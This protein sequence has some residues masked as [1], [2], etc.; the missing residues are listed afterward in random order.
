MS[1]E[2]PNRELPDGNGFTLA[3]VAARFN[4]EMVDALVE[5]VQNSLL[6]AGAVVEVI[7]VP[8]AWELP[9]GAQ[10]AARAGRFDAVIALGVVIAGDTRHHEHIADATGWGIQEVSLKEH[11]PVINGI[12]VTETEE[13]AHARTLGDVDKGYHFALAALEMAGLMQAQPN[14]PA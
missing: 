7:R 4:A 9:L 11:L 13:Q 3:I 10:I 8:G 2:L 6:K 14:S 5:R 1:A 12:L